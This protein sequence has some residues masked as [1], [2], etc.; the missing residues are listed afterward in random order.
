MRTPERARRRGVERRR[1]ARRR[2]RGRRRTGRRNG[3]RCGRDGCSTSSADALRPWSSARRAS[4]A[5]SSRYRRMISFGRQDP[6]EVGRGVVAEAA[7]GSRYAAR[8]AQR[9][10]VEEEL[11]VGD[12]RACRR[13]RARSAGCRCP[14]GSAATARSSRPRRSPGDLQVAR[15]RGE[16]LARVEALVDAAAR[17][18]AGRDLRVAARDAARQPLARGARR[19]ACRAGSGRSR[20]GSG[21]ARPRR[22]GRS[23]ACA[24]GRPALSS[25][26]I[27][28][29]VS[30]SRC[31]RF[32]TRSTSGRNVAV[33]DGGEH[34]AA[35]ALGVEDV[36]EAGGRA[37]LELGAAGGAPG[38]RVLRRLAVARAGRERAGR[39]RAARQQDDGAAPRSPP[40]PAMS[41]ATRRR[42][43]PSA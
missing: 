30:G 20:R 18:Q 39:V 40:P 25:K 36:R 1:A 17:A 4:P 27:A 16:R 3:R 38:E 11:R 15:G 19:S 21:S 5:G 22:R 10:G 26:T 9:R 24:S 7:R 29:S 34:D 41:T 6:P 35:G 32:A 23:S 2:G 13:R 37:P 8:V 42:I 31:G 43:R 12:V 28:S 14:C 33:R